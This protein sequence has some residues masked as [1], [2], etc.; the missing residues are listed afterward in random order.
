MTRQNLL[1]KPWNFMKIKEKP[2]QCDFF[3]LEVFQV[4]IYNEKVMLKL[5]ITEKEEAT[6]SI[7]TE[8]FSNAA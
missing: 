7:V 1:V 8:S 2:I 5:P 4:I 3:V 6:V